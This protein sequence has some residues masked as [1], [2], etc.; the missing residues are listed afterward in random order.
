MVSKGAVETLTRVCAKELGP[1]GLFV[2]AIAPGPILPPPFTPR[3]E[4][5][6]IRAESPVKFSVSDE[7]AVE[8]FSL[9]VLYLSIVTFTSG[10]TFSLDQGQNL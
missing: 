6:G 2:N 8:Q 7:E 10:S 5:E 1:R 3:E 4:W 9:L